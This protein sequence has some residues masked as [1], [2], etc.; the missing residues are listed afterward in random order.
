MTSTTASTNIVIRTHHG[1]SSAGAGFGAS[2]A[3]FLDLK[4]IFVLLAI[5][6]LGGRIVYNDRLGIVHL[7]YP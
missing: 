5:V 2:V 4:I 6:C 1:L 7:R 3:R